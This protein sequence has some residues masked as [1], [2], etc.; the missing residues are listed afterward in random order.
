MEAFSNQ[1]WI[2]LSN[3]GDNNTSKPFVWFVDAN[4]LSFLD[5][6]YFNDFAFKSM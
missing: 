1:K 2:W 4:S 6:F 3:I 5:D